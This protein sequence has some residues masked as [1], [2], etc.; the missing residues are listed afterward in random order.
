MVSDSIDRPE[1]VAFW[2]ALPTLDPEV[3]SSS[4]RTWL[5]A[6]W[7][8]TAQTE[9]ASIASFSRFSLQMTAVGAPPELLIRSHHAAIDE[10]HHARVAFALASRF[11]GQKLGPGPLALHGDLLGDTALAAIAIETAKDGCVNET[12]AAADAAA[13]GVDARVSAVRCAMAIIERDES[14]HAELAWAFIGWAV[15]L[16]G[17]RLRDDVV[18]MIRRTCAEYTLKPIGEPFPMS[19][20]SGYGFLD[21]ERALAVRRDAVAQFILPAAEAL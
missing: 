11:S 2:N 9:H 13:A 15:A 10:V 14:R 18:S 17:N 5:A 3:L 21:P 6:R 20:V 16:A 4:S 8:R 19:E 1:D 7:A 12:L